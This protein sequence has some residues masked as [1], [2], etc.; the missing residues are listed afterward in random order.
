MMTLWAIALA[1]SAAAQDE[2]DRFF[3][4]FKE[5]R[6]S[7]HALEGKFERENITSEGTFRA[8]GELLYVRPRRLIFRHEEPEM[9]D[10][11]V[12]GLR[13]YEYDEELEQLQIRD[14]DDDGR[15]EAL[16]IGFEQDLGRLREAYDIEFFDPGEVK[17]AVKGLV[18]RPKPDPDNEQEP[19]L[20]EALRLYLRAK[21][22]LPVRVVI[23]NNADSTVDIR[24]AGYRINKKLDPRK[25]QIL[26]PEGTVVV[27][28][29]QSFDEVG[30]GGMRF[31]P[32]ALDPGKRPAA[33]A[34]EETP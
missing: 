25:T 32:T 13:V 33:A 7:I 26:V 9:P 17:D 31:P 11:I 34:H 1:V 24:V 21:D 4:E 5:R 6:E 23:V 10:T 8:E 3:E 14:L 30:P 22:Y 12:D 27:E 15:T 16:F 2:L 20:F 28:N 19:R 18:L 29:E